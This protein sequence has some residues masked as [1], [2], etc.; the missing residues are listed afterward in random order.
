MEALTAWIRSPGAVERAR[1]LSALALDG[2]R[3]A[4]GLHAGIE[5]N[6]RMRG[7][8]PGAEIMRF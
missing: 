5:I 2:T 6:D 7:W 3:T 8:V 1:L 4:A